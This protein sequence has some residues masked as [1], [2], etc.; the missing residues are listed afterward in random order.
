MIEHFGRADGSVGVWVSQRCAT[1]RMKE[2][3][4][5]GRQGLMKEKV[6]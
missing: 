4:L 5:E 1:N 6:G 3:R 2:T